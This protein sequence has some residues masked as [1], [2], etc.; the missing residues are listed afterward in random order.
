MKRRLFSCLAV[1]LVLLLSA[2]GAYSLRRNRSADPVSREV[3]KSS[4]FPA[5]PLSQEGAA[6]AKL[7]EMQ[8]LDQ[9]LKKK[10]D[11]TPILFRLAQVAR[12]MGRPAETAEHFRQILRQEPANKEARL[13]LGRVLYEMGDIGGAM[14]ETQE[15]LKKDPANIDALYNMGAIYANLN[16]EAQAREYWLR[17]ISAG[18]ASPSGQL[19]RQ[20]LGQLANTQTKSSQRK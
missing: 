11:H 15:L 9:H 7:A 13:E 5:Q 10:P 6:Q 17:V 1:A 8:T 16:Q 4:L 14:R 18:P 20:S 3:A 12:E 2:L 19:A